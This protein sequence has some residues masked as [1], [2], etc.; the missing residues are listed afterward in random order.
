MHF[1]TFLF[2][3]IN[4]K[5][6][7]KSNKLKKNIFRVN[8][9]SHFSRDISFQSLSVSCFPNLRHTTKP[10]KKHPQS[11]ANTWCTL[12]LSP[13]ALSLF[14]QRS[15][16][17]RKIVSMN[18]LTCLKLLLKSPATTNFDS[19]AIRPGHK[20]AQ[21]THYNLLQGRGT[22]LLLQAATTKVHHAPVHL[23][24]TPFR[25]RPDRSV[26]LNKC[27]IYKCTCFYAICGSSFQR[28]R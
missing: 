15:H 3:Y 1:K 10:A 4:C 24:Q 22:Y 14:Q 25:G 26:H 17:H 28:E 27:N 19:N 21:A 6:Y 13:L 7:N 2:Y 5:G 12:K 20:K 23:Q 8:I 9:N 18:W 16:F 11:Q